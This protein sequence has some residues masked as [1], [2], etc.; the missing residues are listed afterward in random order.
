MNRKGLAVGLIL[1]L[2]GTS[3]IPITAQD[4]EKP[5]PT[6]RGNWLYVGGSGP[7]NYTK[8]QDAINSSS[9][10][11][12]VFVYDDSSP[13]IENLEIDTSISLI[14]EDKDTTIVERKTNASHVPL[15]PI[16]NITADHVTVRGFTIQN[17]SNGA[18]ICLTSNY[19]VITDNI[20]SDTLYG[21][22]TPYG[23]SNQSSSQDKGNNIITNNLLIRNG[24]GIFCVGGGLEIIQGNIISQTEIGIIIMMEISN[25]ISNNDISENTMGVFIVQSFNIVLI[26]NNISSNEIGV[27]TMI[28]S[29]L[30]ILHNNFIG[31]ERNAEFSQIFLESI[32]YFKKSLNRE[33]RNPR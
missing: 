31:N 4:A 8:I 14:G 10:G 5:L 17:S 6:S 12:T 9:D 18:G 32:K 16:I 21:I 26:R 7:G 33:C 27:F 13:Y 29:A 25:N 28:T 23:Y 1:L 15:L 30:R 2:I 20:I 19:N 11:D 24:G 3:V 22:V